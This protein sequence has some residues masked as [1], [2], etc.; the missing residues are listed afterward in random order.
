MAYR[1]AAASSCSSLRCRGVARSR[2][3][4]NLAS[5]RYPKNAT[6]TTPWA[7]APGTEE[8]PAQT[9]STLNVA[10]QVGR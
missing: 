9:F 1:L 3:T 8:R 2:C 5:S 4:M 6:T 7:T 10:E